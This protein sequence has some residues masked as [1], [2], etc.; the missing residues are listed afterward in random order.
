MN[1]KAQKNR[2]TRRQTHVTKPKLD[3]HFSVGYIA[4]D[5]V[6]LCVAVALFILSLKLL[7]IENNEHLFK[8]GEK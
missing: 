4:S 6:T 5:I 3:T 7:I 8:D 1:L 2:A